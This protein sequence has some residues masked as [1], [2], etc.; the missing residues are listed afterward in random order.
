MQNSANISLIF[1]T[2]GS[3][4]KRELSFRMTLDKNGQN[5]TLL[6]HSA[7]NIY[8]ATGRFIIEY[9]IQYE[10]NKFTLILRE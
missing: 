9:S 2:P 5:L 10:I 3:K 4:Q 6:I 8:K 1:D 7:N